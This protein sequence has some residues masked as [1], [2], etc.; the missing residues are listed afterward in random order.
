MT[1]VNLIVSE[2]T[3]VSIHAVGCTVY[4]RQSVE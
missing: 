4:R 2:V 3:K 1:Q